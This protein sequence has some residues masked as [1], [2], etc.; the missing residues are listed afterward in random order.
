[1]IC[2]LHCCHQPAPLLSSCCCAVCAQAQIFQKKATKLKHKMC[3][4]SWKMGM[5]L[6]LAVLAALAIIVISAC[7]SIAAGNKCKPS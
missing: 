5:L 2:K 3:W 4:Q 7:F 6:G 1:M